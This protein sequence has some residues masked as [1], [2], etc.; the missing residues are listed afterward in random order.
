MV[1]LDLRDSPAIEAFAQYLATALEAKGK[2]LDAVVR[3]GRRALARIQLTECAR[4]C[5]KFD[6]LLCCAGD[7]YSS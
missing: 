4:K 1:G 7:L 5:R 3:K 2:G 6:L